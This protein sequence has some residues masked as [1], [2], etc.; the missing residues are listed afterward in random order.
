MAIALILLFVD[1]HY[2]DWIGKT[3]AEGR[4]IGQEI[5]AVVQ[6]EMAS[7]NRATAVRMKKGQ[8]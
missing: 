5:T 8:E 3:E 6:E 1:R 4:K 7:K 2:K